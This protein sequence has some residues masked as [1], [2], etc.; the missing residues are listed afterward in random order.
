MNP[1]NLDKSPKTGYV[2]KNVKGKERVRYNSADFSNSV[3]FILC[4]WE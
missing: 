1:Q 2:K 4:G 3:S